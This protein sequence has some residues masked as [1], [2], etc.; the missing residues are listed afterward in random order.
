L[1][2]FLLFKLLTFSVLITLVFKLTLLV[3]FFFLPFPFSV[4]TNLV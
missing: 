4:L 2:L 3:S 1:G